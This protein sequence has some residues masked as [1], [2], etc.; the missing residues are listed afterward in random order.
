MH[1]YDK[2]LPLNRTLLIL[3]YLWETTDEE[4]TASLADITAWFPVSSAC[5]LDRS[6]HI[7]KALTLSFGAVCLGW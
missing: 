7:R 3:R 4:H 6:W 5:S 2:K 1:R